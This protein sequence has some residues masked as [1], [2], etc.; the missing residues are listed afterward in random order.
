MDERI[1][2]R[3]GKNNIKVVYA[4]VIHGGGREHL[5]MVQ[6]TTRYNLIPKLFLDCDNIVYRD[7]FK[8]EYFIIGRK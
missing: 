8:D 1:T 5:E 4:A 2:I 6:K 7:T 3:T